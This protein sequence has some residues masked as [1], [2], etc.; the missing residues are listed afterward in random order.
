MAKKFQSLIDRV[1]KLQTSGVQAPDKATQEAWEARRTVPRLRPSEVTYRDLNNYFLSSGLDYKGQAQSAYTMA[2]HG[3]KGNV[4]IDPG[5]VIGMAAELGVKGGAKHAT[6]A[7]VIAHRHGERVGD[8]R[9]PAPLALNVMV[10]SM[11]EGSVGCSLEFGVS[12][13]LSLGRKYT[14]STGTSSGSRKTEVKWIND[15]EEADE[16]D[17][18]YS[19][20][21]AGLSLEAKAGFA[22]EG[23]YTYTHLYL[24]DNAPLYFVERGSDLRQAL[25]N[26]FAEKVDESTL[27]LEAIRWLNHNKTALN[28]S[29]LWESVFWMERSASKVGNELFKAVQYLEN[30][31]SPN[32]ELLTSGRVHLAKVKPYYDAISQ[33]GI[34]HFRLSSHAPKGEAGLKASAS[35]SGHVGGVASASAEV[36][37]EGLKFEAS[38]KRSGY[39]YQTKAAPTSF[40]D[41]RGNS[42]ARSNAVTSTTEAGMGSGWLSPGLILMTQDTVIQYSQIDFTALALKGSTEGTLSLPGYKHGDTSASAPSR[43]KELWK[44]EK[45]VSVGTKALLHRISYRTA[46]TYWSP[47]TPELGSQRKGTARY[48]VRGQ[49]GTGAAF[50]TSIV[51]ENLL[52]WM[53]RYDPVMGEWLE[54]GTQGEAYF[55]GLADALL[56]DPA[57]LKEALCTAETIGLIQDLVH[58]NNIT[59]ILLESTYGVPFRDI[60]L[61]IDHKWETLSE[62]VKHYYNLNNGSA[63]AL[64]TSVESLGNASLRKSALQSIRIRYRLRD[65]H[66]NDSSLFKLGFK[67]AGT[68]FGFELES[69]DRAGNEGIVDLA[70]IWT[71]SRTYSDDDTVPASILFCQ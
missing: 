32:A 24:E 63:Q 19:Y 10:G 70:T 4:S 50:G 46:I 54:K 67:I 52:H 43:S 18:P 66:N 14:P 51:P 42:R 64:F 27:K 68:G 8:R 47:P 2:G 71:G 3:L 59:S 58:A 5:K 6:E 1:I 7:L 57:T 49:P 21:L 56:T 16:P 35:A 69:V 65:T 29:G 53:L 26:V 37:A 41:T 38:Y 13:S 33:D 23:S 12:A 9:V 28:S 45:G 20:E 11:W 48:T 22:A 17:K 60:P 15:P 36:S 44:K 39:R 55:Q 25:V 34:C 40:R 30:S 61:T 62:G 31:E